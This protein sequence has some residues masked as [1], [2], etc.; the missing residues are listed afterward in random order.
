MQH[1][2]QVGSKVMVSFGKRT[3]TG[4]IVEILQGQVL[5]YKT[6]PLLEVANDEAPA[7]TREMLELTR[8]IADYYLCSWGE[9]I[10]AALPT[11]TNQEKPRVRIKKVRHVR[12]APAL[13][14]QQ[15]FQ[16]ARSAIRGSKQ[17]L[18]LDT[19]STLLD[20]GV[21]EPSQAELLA[22]TSA[23][24]SS[25]KSLHKQHLV[26]VFEKE[27][28]R[29][30]LGEIPIDGE[31]PPAHTLHDAQE[32]A[33]Q[34]ILQS[35]QA[36]K[37]ETFLLHGVTGSGKTEVY[38]AALKE[39]L[40]AGKTGIVLVPEIA[41]TPQTVARFRAHFGDRIAVLH[42]R[43]SL[44]ERYDAWR[45][46]RNGRFSVVIGPRS[47]IL[48]PLSNIGL[49]VVDEEH[50]SSYK[51]FDPAPRYHARDV[52]VMR[53]SLNNAVC[54]LGSATPSLE[55][56][57]NAM[58]G[59]KYTYLSMPKRVPVPGHEAAPLPTIRPIDLTME[60]RRRRLP[61][62]LS[63]ALRLA[64]SERIE[65]EEQVILLQNRRGYAAIVECAD[66]GWSPVC[67]DCAVTLTYHKV[68]HH[69]RCHYCGQTQRLPRRCPECGGADI[70]R[71]GAGTQRI[72][73]ELETLF[74][75]AR[76]LRMD[77]DTTTG[78]NAHFKILDQ[79]ARGEADILV[80]TQMVAKGLDFGRVT[81]VGVVNADVGMLL[82]DFRAEERTFQL[83][84]QVAG[85]AGRSKLR[86][87][88]ILQTRNP[89]HPALRFAT[90]HEYDNFAQ[91]ALGQRR[92]LGYPPYGRVIRVEFR[93]PEEKTVE[94]IAR[95]W[96]QALP[97]LKDV[98]VLGPQPAF[99]SRIQK[100]YRFHIIFKAP[101]RISMQY[102]GQLIKDAST[103]A[104]ALPR[105]YR[106]AV[107]VDAVALY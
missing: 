20:Q 84:T 60:K 14:A 34:K 92:A 81:L 80:G 90:R 104:G 93:G 58:M 51:Q 27:V 66:C 87:E 8:W 25:L 1:L 75:E 67:V 28:L 15:T 16:E 94:D 64:I 59:Q 102:L 42:S 50:E 53:A 61:G 43:M 48:A 35:I 45:N 39:V 49:I 98:Q 40:A 33:L 96:R 83:L 37:F 79:F 57:V 73:E 4:L 22:Q 56:Y 32:Q 19:L 46:L 88:V 44:G 9:V 26:E 70:S 38:I 10:R 91:Y 11:G 12:L 3:L 24:A 31:P 65:R 100:N 54:I 82:P 21:E 86:G 63:Q 105:N 68:Q 41:L 97:Q 30:P 69:L 62:A 6:K 52:A 71:L 106:I 101:R 89:E 74:P 72:E 55:S 77:L 99:I 76:L 7:F 95:R 29:T 85:R 36:A 78:K 107:D 13:K 17:L 103:K 2:A 5:A 47:A 18:I 23:T